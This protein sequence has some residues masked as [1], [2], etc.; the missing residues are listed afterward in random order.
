MEDIKM[1]TCLVQRSCE[2]PGYPLQR[3]GAYLHNVARGDALLP[4]AIIQ[5]GDHDAA[6]NE[7]QASTVI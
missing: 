3:N 5:S 7:G 1:K 6:F 2:K 4:Q